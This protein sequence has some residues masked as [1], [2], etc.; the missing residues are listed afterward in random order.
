METYS[1]ITTTDSVAR[2]DLLHS[3]GHELPRAGLTARQ[4]RLA[5]KAYMLPSVTDRQLA[6]LTSHMPR[7]AELGLPVQSVTQ[8]AV[9]LERGRGK[10]H[11]DWS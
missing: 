7:E 4:A 3:D 10:P 1:E 5:G 2:T 11:A 6:S 9:T 8:R